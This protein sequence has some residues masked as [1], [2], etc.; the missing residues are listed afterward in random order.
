MASFY[1]VCGE[2]IRN[3]VQINKKELK[4]VTKMAKE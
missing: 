1:S 4:K 3:T 2:G